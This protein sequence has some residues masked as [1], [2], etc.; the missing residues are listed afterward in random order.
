MRLRSQVGKAP[1]QV[2]EAP[3][4]DTWPMTGLFCSECFKIGMAEPQRRT[5][6]G[7]VCK[8]GHGGAEGIEKDEHGVLR[9]NVKPAVSEV[10]VDVGISYAENYSGKPP[11]VV[12][13][14]GS[15]SLEAHLAG[16]EGPEPDTDEFLESTVPTSSGFDGVV[17]S[18]HVTD[19]KALYDRLVKAL[20]LG[21]QARN[22][23][24]KLR[25]AI[26]EAEDNARLA[27][28]LYC[29]AV[30]EFERW[31]IEHEPVHGDLW[32]Q[33][34]DLLERD[35]AGKPA[36][37]KKTITNEDVKAKAASTFTDEWKRHR[38]GAKKMK[39][40]VEHCKELADIW[41]QRCKTLNTM[42]GTAR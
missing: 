4:F 5:P 31:E 15:H 10:A 14:A 1:P 3:V 36:K 9:E 34:R 26:D 16:V 20:K 13:V 25:E 22:D 6:S 8:F 12:P 33:A 30:M 40:L 19:V 24:G 23:K 17:E 38:I 21:E 7:D 42:L 39:L 37:D 28:L 2:T 35:Q 41:S 11:Q 32:A 27:H 18:M 29:A